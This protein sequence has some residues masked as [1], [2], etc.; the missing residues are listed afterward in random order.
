MG[1][2]AW[3]DGALNGQQKELFQILVN[4]NLNKSLISN[5]ITDTGRDE[6]RER[7][8]N[9]LTLKGRALAH[10]LTQL[11]DRKK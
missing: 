2:V 7:E 6:Q 1:K 5:Q 9:R 11:H 10:F 4:C 8:V 3:T